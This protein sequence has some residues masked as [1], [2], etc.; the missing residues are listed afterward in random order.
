MHWRKT[1]SNCL[2]EV[3]QL[4]V[5]P[6]YCGKW[7]RA[8]QTIDEFKGYSAY[9][10]GV[11]SLKANWKNILLKIAERRNLYVYIRVRSL[12]S[13]DTEFPQRNKKIG[14]IIAGIF[15]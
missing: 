11:I 5:P 15:L 14:C 6:Y 1:Y 12:L 8:V 7:A 3:P 9:V 10:I 4:L 13:S 2:R